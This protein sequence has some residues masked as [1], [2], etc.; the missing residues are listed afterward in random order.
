MAM[1]SL[2][3]ALLAR[4]KGAPAFQPAA[5]PK[6]NL[7]PANCVDMFGTGL[8]VSSKVFL[9]GAFFLLSL[10]PIVCKLSALL[11]RTASTLLNGLLDRKTTCNPNRLLR[12]VYLTANELLIG[13]G[14]K[15]I[16][17]FV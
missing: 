3:A 7:G 14:S 15:R 2:L 4:G 17:C 12:C 6:L 1:I 8:S 10:F 13:W 9:G 11:P 16:P 5:L